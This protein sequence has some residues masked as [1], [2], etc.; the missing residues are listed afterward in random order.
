MSTACNTN[1]DI[2]MTPGSAQYERALAALD[3]HSA[4]VDDRSL[5]DL[6]LFTAKLSNHIK[7]YSLH[8]VESGTWSSFFQ[9]DSSYLLCNIQDIDV[10]YLV[11]LYQLSLREILLLKDDTEGQGELITDFKTQI[12]GLVGKLLENALALPDDLQIKEFFLGTK[13]KLSKLKDAILVELEAAKSKGFVEI[14]DTLQNH[15]F[16]NR[17]NALLGLINEWKLKSNSALVFS[18]KK[19]PNHSPHYALYLSFVQLFSE[20]QEDQN[21]FTK[22]HLDFYYKEVLLLKPQHAQPDS[23]H[24]NIEPQKNQQAFLLPQGTKFSAGKN[25][26]GKK[27]YYATV[28]DTVVNQAKINSIFSTLK[29][30]NQLYYSDRTELNGSGESFPAFN[31][32]T[33]AEYGMAVTS[34]ILYLQSGTRT[35]TLNFYYGSTKLKINFQDFTYYLSSK[36]GWKEVNATGSTLVIGSDE[37]PIIP[38][39]KEVHIDNNFDTTNP[40]LKIIPKGISKNISFTKLQIDVDVKE[41]NHFKIYSQNGEVDTNKSFY[42]FG[43]FPQNGMS[44]LF[45]SNEFFQKRHAIGSLSVSSNESELDKETELEYL[46]KGVWS[47]EVKKQIFKLEYVAQVFQYE[48]FIPQAQLVPYYLAKNANIGGLTSEVPTPQLA[49]AQVINILGVLLPTNDFHSSTL[50]IYSEQSRISSTGTEDEYVSKDKKNGYVKI[51][52]QHKNYDG[53]TYLK[54]YLNNVKVDGNISSIPVPPTIESLHFNYTASQTFGLKNDGEDHKLLQVFPRGYKALREQGKFNINPNFQNKGDIYIGIQHIQAGNVANILFQVADG[55]AN[56]LIEPER[57]SWDIL[58]DNSWSAIK[59]LNDTTTGLTQSGIISFKVPDNFFLENQTRLPND[60]LWIKIG[61]PTK[62]ETICNLLGVHA[63]ACKAVLFD[64]NPE[65]IVFEKNIEAGTISKILNPITGVKKV[66]QFY[67]SFYGR[68]AESEEKFYIRSSERLRHKNKAITLWD[69]ERL[70]LEK[71]PQ[72]HMVKCL[73]HYRYEGGIRNNTSAGYITIIPIAQNSSST[74]PEYW[75]PLVDIGTM[76]SIEQYI[77]KKA[78][79]HVRINVRT[80]IL[81]KIKLTFD[82]HF[83]EMPGND[84]EVLSQNLNDV[85]KNFLSPWLIQGTVEFKRSISKSEIIRLIDQQQYVDHLSNLVIRHQM[86]DKKMF[87]IVEE[88]QPSTEYSLLIPSKHSINPIT[89]KCCPL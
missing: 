56:P 2:H 83:K 61:L 57:I 21:R 6:I 79:P 39:D 41:S 22:R 8:N 70:I 26:D 62:D 15:L 75:K 60:S 20:A 11:S 86:P 50:S 38:F 36:E 65:N 46:K 19:Y 53:N 88:L 89:E 34:P 77:Q 3:V 44:M 30:N 58:I 85:I 74:V 29:K 5:M 76:K 73:N 45:T 68:E 32:E 66:H 18:L 37:E 67:E 49:T 25:A 27:R 48:H 81:E 42:P 78:S 40:V 24:L 13:Q 33:I 7:Y 4:K 55:T 87:D 59:N 28:A 12:E 9:N 14:V 47:E 10:Q 52:L 72:V 31:A 1:I 35:I 64:E 84:N 71:F 16:S 80:P 23:V 82:V 43:E 51:I 63:Q 54:N 17:Y 69:Y